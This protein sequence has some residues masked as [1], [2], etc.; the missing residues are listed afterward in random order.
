MVTKSH[1]PPSRGLYRGSY[2]GVLQGSLRRILGVWTIAQIG[3]G[4]VEGVA[5]M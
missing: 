1:R 2:R 3:P 5:G 4:P